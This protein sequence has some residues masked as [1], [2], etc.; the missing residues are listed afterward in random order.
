VSELINV[1]L[2]DFIGGDK[3]NIIAD[4]SEVVVLVPADKANEFVLF[5]Q[6]L[7]EDI[8]KEFP[9]EVIEIDVSESNSTAADMV[10]TADSQAN[11]L[12]VIM[13]LPDGAMSMEPLSLDQTRTSNNVGVVVTE[14]D[15]TTIEVL[16]RS[17]LTSQMR[18]VEAMI[19][20]ICDLAGAKV[21]KIEEF[22]PWSPNFIS[23][24][25][26]VAKKSHFNVTQEE[27]NVKS[28]HAGL[29]PAV[30]DEELP[31]MEKVSIGPTLGDVHGVNEWADT[32]SVHEFWKRLLHLLISI[33][34]VNE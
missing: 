29:E 12:K 22:P 14:A 5:C 13:A 20:S 23:K 31:E 6:K 1:Y 33:N 26:A 7:E 32:E 21:E 11:L 9:K 3:M 27:P 10:M 8:Q 24:L 2:L 15:H 16:L 34:Q 25:L 18:Y 28:I 30:V 4:N 17:S 19:D